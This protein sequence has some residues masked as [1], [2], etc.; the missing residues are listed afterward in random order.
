MQFW[1]RGTTDKRFSRV[2]GPNFT[3]LGEDIERSFIHKNFVLAFGYLA[4]FSNASDSILSD[5]E[6][7]TFN[8]PP[9]KIRRWMGEISIPVVEALLTNG[10]HLMAIHC[11]AADSAEQG[12]L[13]KQ[14]EK[15]VHGLKI[16]AFPTT[17]GGLIM[18]YTVCILS[19]TV[20]K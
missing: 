3:K 20:S 18:L 6:F 13:I 4:A 9:V 12:G 7:R 16:K 5:V 10:I 2:R 19:R 1:E 8:P 15:N 14:K 17:S 11:V